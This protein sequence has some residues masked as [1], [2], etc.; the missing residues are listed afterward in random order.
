MSYYARASAKE[1]EKV[2]KLREKGLSIR[3]IAAVMKKNFMWVFR[4][5]HSLV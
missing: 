5:I 2:R 3:S 1:I 4:V